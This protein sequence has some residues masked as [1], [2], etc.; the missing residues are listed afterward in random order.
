MPFM[1]WIRAMPHTSKGFSQ[2]NKLRQLKDIN[3]F[4]AKARKIPGD[5]P[6]P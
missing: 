4:W 2:E 3:N 6:P 5:L 1:A